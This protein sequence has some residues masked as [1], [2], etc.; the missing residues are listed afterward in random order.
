MVAARLA[1]AASRSPGGRKVARDAGSRRERNKQDK[2]RR[3]T[4]AARRLF[5]ERGFEATTTQAIAEAADIGTG[6]LFSYVRVKED[7]LLMVFLDDLLAVI[8]TALQ[9]TRPGATLVDKV[10]HLFDSLLRFHSR[11]LELSRHF[12]R[13]TY[14]VRTPERRA[15]INRLM[16]AI[17]DPLA[18]MIVHEQARGGVRADADPK[19]VAWQFFAFYFG[20][21]SG[22]VNNMSTLRE[23]RALLRDANNELFRGLRP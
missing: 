6:T 15:D 7:L 1:R 21:V 16:A 2:L 10:F 5:Y 11:D 23:G 20:V 8:D 4:E 19:T 22:M 3:I 18:Q 13:E 17:L 12:T 9:S 14:A